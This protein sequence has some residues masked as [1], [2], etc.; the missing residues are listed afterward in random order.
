[1]GELLAPPA[2]PRMAIAP[3]RIP[4]T[5]GSAFRAYPGDDVVPWPKRRDELRLDGARRRASPDDQSVSR[6]E[7]LQVRMSHRERALEAPSA[8]AH[9]EHL[10]TAGPHVDNRASPALDVLVLQLEMRL[11]EMGGHLP[12]RLNHGAASGLGF[13]AAPAGC[14]A[15]GDCRR[16]ERAGPAAHPGCGRP[17]RRARQL[18]AGAT[19]SPDSATSRSPGDDPGRAPAGREPFRRSRIVG[20]LARARPAAFERLL[21]GLHLGEGRAT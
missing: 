18:A 11:A 2:R 6:R 13:G 10:T 1:M 19:G 9:V 20:S 14:R 16:L 12:P 5:G 8:E 17:P 15:R 3:G 21:A 7:V 4:S